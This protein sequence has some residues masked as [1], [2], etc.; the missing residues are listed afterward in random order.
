MKKFLIVLLISLFCFIPVNAKEEK[1][2]IVSGDL[3]TV[4]SEVCF[5]TECFYVIGN[6]GN[7]V[8]LFSKYNLYAGYNCKSG[9]KTTCVAYGDEAT[10]IQDSSMSGWIAGGSSDNRNGVVAFTDNIYWNDGTKI[11]DEY[12]SSYPIDIYN[13]NSNLYSYV[14]NYK[15]YFHNNSV[16]V[17]QARLI[18]YDE[19]IDLK[20]RSG[21]CT[22]S[23]K[24]LYTS[25]YWVGST[26]GN[27]VVS[28]VNTNGLLNYTSFDNQ[29]SFGVRPVIEVPIGWFSEE[30]TVYAGVVKNTNV[31]NGVVSKNNVNIDIT[32][33]DLGQEAKYEAIIYNDTDSVMYVHD[34][35]LNELEE[36]F[37]DIR[38]DSKSEN[39]MIEPN[40]SSQ[41][42]FYINTLKQEGAGRNFN[43]KISINF[44]ISD[45]NLNPNTFSNIFEVLILIFVLGG[46]I[47]FVKNKKNKKIKTLILIVTLSLL[48]ITYVNAKDY[49]IVTISGNIKYVSQNIIETT[50]TSLNG[51]KADYTNSKDVW[52]YYDKVKSIEVKS[53]IDKPKKYY[54]EFDLTE[55][56]S[57]RVMGYLIE[58][59]DEDIPYD[60]IIMSNGVVAANSDSSFMFS[61]PSVEK[62]EGLSNVDFRGATT[63]QG[64]F[65]GNKKL[66][67]VDKDSLEMNN[68]INTSYMFY[69]CDK[70][71]YT[72]SDFKLDNV[73]NSIMM[74]DDNLYNEIKSD[75]ISDSSLTYHSG[76]GSGKYFINST[77]NDKFP[78]YFYR[79]NV[80]NNNVVFAN[81]CWKMVRTTDTGGIKL[82]YNGTPAD[83]GSCNN[84]GENSIVGTTKQTNSTWSSYHNGSYMYGNTTMSISS[85]GATSYSFTLVHKKTLSSTNSYYFSKDVSYSDGKYVF[86]DPQLY[87]FG[88]KY[89]EL[90]GYYTYFGTSSTTSDRFINYVLFADST[91]VYYYQL[92]NGNLGND[93]YTFYKDYEMNDDGSFKLLDP[94]TISRIDYYNGKYSDFMNYYINSSDNNPSSNELLL[95]IKM[96]SMSGGNCTGRSNYIYGKDYK[97][98]N[99][100][101]TL[102]DTKQIIHGKGNTYKD[103]YNYNYTCA[104]RTGKCTG[105]HYITQVTENMLYY[106][107][108]KNNET[109]EQGLNSIYANN[110]NSLIKNVVDSWY[111]NNMTSYTN[112][113]EDT[114]WYND[115]TFTDGKL[116]SINN[117]SSVTSKFST[118]HRLY[119]LKQAPSFEYK[120]KDDMFTVS[121]EIGNGKLTYPV[122][123]ITGDEL[124]L[125]ASGPRRYNTNNYLQ[126]G[127]GWWTLSPGYI[128]S[129][130]LYVGYVSPKGYWA[131][132]KGS[133]SYGVRPMVSLKHGVLYSAG[134]G[135]VNNPYVIE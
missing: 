27:S 44:K 6:D 126:I 4:G 19:L 57:G 38:L 60:L 117:S 7:N 21:K 39:M 79:G 25:A 5:D 80:R 130:V 2:K 78:I 24:W 134:D 81:Y 46:T 84:T 129:S 62:V 13:S 48:G 116:A 124:E 77:A 89:N 88:E 22:N 135:T 33:N 114:V 61:F 122:G 97:Y 56:K 53:L 67:N 94:V 34:I 32:F 123:L 132:D 52:T 131:F 73:T 105:L 54:K 9:Y 75:S 106:Y 30:G 74:F 28:M 47:Y 101:Y 115:R 50:G 90:G 66:S 86:Q 55:N 71:T 69:D 18:T 64:M 98:E 85:K 76:S 96:T 91:T 43:D 10:G 42:T 49:D 16:P 113:L 65:I 31:S 23:Y 8:K 37:I 111:R 41:V 95:Q 108:L 93:N 14:E 125:A 26:V 40:G 82:I 112:L 58:N 12:G 133:N 59:D 36:D 102:L 100:E 119:T 104:N 63:M 20:C 68:T 15:S 99:G 1:Y 92:Y 121:S 103:I 83:D 17:I 110:R 109:V 107:Y 120:D 3:E 35:N 72:K 118:Y 128:S 70:I 11:Y 87:N 45:K 29:V 51:K 127:T